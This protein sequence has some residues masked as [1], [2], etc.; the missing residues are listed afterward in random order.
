MS[1]PCKSQLC[2]YEQPD[3][4]MQSAFFWERSKG[5]WVPEVL[6]SALNKFYNKDTYLH[7]YMHKYRH[8][9]RMMCG[10]ALTKL[11]ER[12]CSWYFTSAAFFHHF[13]AITTVADLYM[14]VHLD[15]TKKIP[16]PN[17]KTPKTKQKSAD[18]ALQIEAQWRHKPRRGLCEGQWPEC[19]ACISCCVRD[20]AMSG[21]K[22][23]IKQ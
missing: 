22:N 13:T 21:L 9:Y 18:D 6:P 14:E 4:N 20:E 1:I 8:L 23:K 10:Y 5:T 15:A 2:R 7:A 17:K 12:D 19:N 3:L 16:K 11:D